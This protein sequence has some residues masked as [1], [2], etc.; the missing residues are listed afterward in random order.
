M[1]NRSN[2][3][4]LKTLFLLSPL[5]GFIFSIRNAF[6]ER[7]KQSLYHYVVMLSIFIAFF[8]PT[9]DSLLKM[10]GIRFDNWE[11]VEFL[12]GDPL[13]NIAIAFNSYVDSVY[14]VV[15]YIFLVYFF[16]YKSIV[17]NFD[18]EKLPLSVV[19]VTLCGIPLR[20]GA[21]ITYSTLAT[22]LALYLSI[23][24][25]SKYIYYIP[26]LFICYCCHPF[27]MLVLPPAM[28][29]NWLFNHTK[30][31]CG[32]VFFAIYGILTYSLFNGF[33]FSFDLT[34]LIFEENV[35][36]FTAYTSSDSI[37]GSAGRVL[38][39][40]YALFVFFICMQVG[41]MLIISLKNKNLFKEMS[42][43]FMSLCA[44]LLYNCFDFYTFRERSLVALSISAVVLF[45]KAVSVNAI[46]GQ[47][48]KFFSFTVVAVFLFTFLNFPQPRN[49]LFLNDGWDVS[50][51]GGCLM[52]SYVSV[53]D[54]HDFGYSDSYLNQNASDWYRAKR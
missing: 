20:H 13:S 44:I 23:K 9:Y 28:I 5:F 26:I 30:Y 34:G 21:D 47:M 3:Y 27:I 45:S 49:H 38:G 17:L 7:S 51:I 16:F 46:V 22:V 41:C 40:K 35:R 52:P 53:L 24:Y 1:N 6:V 25:N 14:F 54:M 48:K 10:Q 50:L 15:L 32:F 31:V 37:W 2:A 42:F 43:S 36:S 29:S 12:S 19:V 8:Y 33:D 4:L 18:N 39:L 11:H